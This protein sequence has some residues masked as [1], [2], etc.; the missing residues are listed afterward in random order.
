MTDTSKD[1]QDALEARQK[2]YQPVYQDVYQVVYDA[3]RREMK[4]LIR[5]VCVY[6][7]DC[8]E[9]LAGGAERRGR[10]LIK[11]AKEALEND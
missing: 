8:M 3:G 9:I 5:D 6:L 7:E 10:E 2:I 4:P 1:I 11:R